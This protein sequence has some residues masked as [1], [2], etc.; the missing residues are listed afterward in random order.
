MR[1]DFLDDEN[2]I[3]DIIKKWNEKDKNAEV[4]LYTYAYQK[5]RKI[6]SNVKNKNIKPENTFFLI[7]QNTTS[8]VH[9]AFIKLNTSEYVNP[10]SKIELYATFS[11]VIYSILVDEIR[12]SNAKKRNYLIPENKPTYEQ[13]TIIDIEHELEK[14]YEKYPRQASSFVFKYVCRLSTKEI[15]NMLNISTSSVDKDLLFVKKTLSIHPGN[16]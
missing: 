9:E 16:A 5:F 2:K 15:S 1:N 6:A 14:I 3:L 8:L 12:K 11:K 13:N 7:S 4:Q 10:N